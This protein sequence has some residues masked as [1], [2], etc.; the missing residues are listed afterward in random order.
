MKI[1]NFIEKQKEKSFGFM[2]ICALIY[3]I[4]VTIPVIYFMN[5][6]LPNSVSEYFSDDYDE[7]I[8]CYIEDY[9]LY[10]NEDYYES[11]NGE[12]IV[13]LD[14]EKG[15]YRLV[16]DGLL[17][18]RDSMYNE[19][20]SMSY[21]YVLSVLGYESNDMTKDDVVEFVDTVVPVFG[22]LVYGF[23]LLFSYIGFFI[24]AS[25]WAAIMMLL[26]RWIL[27]AELTYGE[28]FKIY[29]YVMLFYALINMITLLTGSFVL[30][31]LVT[32]FLWFIPLIGV[33]FSAAIYFGLYYLVLRKNNN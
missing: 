7:E 30:K 5:I 24:L 17:L 31:G 13:D 25:F 33:V 18:T 21:E 22:V 12:L 28:S 19:S 32:E 9:E 2:F 15:D 6:T 23:T 16:G 1:F 29:G 3:A 11:E 26:T 8:G 4:L 14:Y 10:C 20:T 27:K